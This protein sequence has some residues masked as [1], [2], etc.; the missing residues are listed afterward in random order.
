MQESIQLKNDKS[1]FNI[2]LHDEEQECSHSDIEIVEPCCKVKGSSGYIECA[3]GGVKDII[4]HNP[5]CTGIDDDFLIE[6]IYGGG[7]ECES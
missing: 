3:C 4:C 6:K 1:V 7:S 2:D 5:D